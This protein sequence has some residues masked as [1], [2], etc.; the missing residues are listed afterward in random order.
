M[1]DRDLEIIKYILTWE[2]GDYSF[3]FGLR[4]IFFSIVEIW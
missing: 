3:F 1:F 4:G 2:L